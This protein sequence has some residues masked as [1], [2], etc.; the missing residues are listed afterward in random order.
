MKTGR[1]LRGSGV[2]VILAPRSRD[3]TG[4]RAHKRP[5]RHAPRS[6]QPDRGS[7][8]AQATDHFQTGHGTCW[9]VQESAEAIRV[10][11]RDGARGLPPRGK[12]ITTVCSLPSSFKA[13]PTGSAGCS[14][15]GC[16]CRGRCYA[17]LRSGED[18][19]DEAV[20]KRH[21]D[22]RGEGYA[23]CG[24]HTSNGGIELPWPTYCRWKE[25]AAKGK[26]P[27]DGSTGFGTGQI[28]RIA[29]Q[30]SLWPSS[31]RPPSFCASLLPACPPARECVTKGDRYIHHR[32]Q[33]VVCMGGHSDC[34]CNGRHRWCV[35]VSLLEK[36]DGAQGAGGGT[37]K[38]WFRPHGRATQ[39]LLSWVAHM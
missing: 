9:R 2:I 15:R 35:C 3:G 8:T 11:L 16:R 28:G 24:R 32:R 21:A 31:L 7:R 12:L 6:S 4:G 25:L 38:V 10:E 37:N 34:R 17:A 1:P 22:T 18:E 5:E 13:C 39:L 29:S 26:Q 20:L 33:A 19:P 30:Y 27:G 14:R 23:V 36:G